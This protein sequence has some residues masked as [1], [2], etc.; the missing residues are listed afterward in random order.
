LNDDAMNNRTNDDTLDP[1]VL[2]ALLEAV[3]PEAPPARLRA[4]VL[5]RARTAALPDF[6]TVRAGVPW[7]ELAPGIEYKLL[8]YD[9]QAGAKSFLLRAAAGARLPA[10]DHGGF[11]ECLVLEGEFELGDLRLRAGDFHAANVGAPHGPAYTATG[12]LVYLRAALAD[13]PGVRP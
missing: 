1:E 6:I 8:V 5:E 4:R 3:P 12:T 11:E 2:S 13:Y 9:E 10:H 7:R